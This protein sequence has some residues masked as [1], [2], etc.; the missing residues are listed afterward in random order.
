M[1]LVRNMLKHAITLTY[2]SIQPGEDRNID[3]DLDT[4]QACSRRATCS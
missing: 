4:R 1:A 3:P 2:G